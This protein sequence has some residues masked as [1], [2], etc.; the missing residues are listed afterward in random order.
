MYEECVSLCFLEFTLFVVF[1]VSQALPACDN[2][3][4]ERRHTAMAAATAE[5]AAMETPVETQPPSAEG[6]LSVQ[7]PAD[8]PDASG[9]VEPASSQP[10]ESTAE[11]KKVT[12]R[13]CN[14]ETDPAE[15]LCQEKFRADLRWTCKACHALLTQLNRHGLE[16]KS[17]LSETDAVSFFQDCKDARKNSVDQRLSYTQA[18]GILKQS[19]IESASRVSTEGEDGEFQPLSYWELKGYDTDKIEQSA[20]KRTH[21]LLGDTYKVDIESTS[22][23]RIHSVTEERIL[24][25]ESEAR[26]RAR[27][28]AQPKAPLAAPMDLPVVMDDLQTGRKRKT[29]EEK[30]ELQEQA[31]AQRQEDKKR[32]KMEVAAC[33]AAAKLLPQ[34]KKCHE[35]L[36]GCNEKIAELSL[37][38]AL[39]DASKEQLESAQ[40]TLD[41]AIGNCSKILGA[42]ARGSSLQSLTAHE[43]ASDKELN[44]VV[45]D[46]NAA[47][48]TAQTF[49]KTNKENMPKKVAK[50]KAK[51]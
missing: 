10:E 1:F 34:L 26:E 7:V 13:R 12:C 20:E 44:T 6:A 48:R 38:V 18:R 4:S 40:K 39:P 21:K 51:K 3:A 28:K 37:T 2:C 14:Q 31:K 42:T 30:K 45:K 23:K 49:I 50:A 29:P 19:M 35:K 36:A 9:A 46:C 43:L 17:V 47:I 33:G 24:K 8:R 22:T 15:A 32:Q 41:L 5:S 11:V 25:M 16:L 27:A